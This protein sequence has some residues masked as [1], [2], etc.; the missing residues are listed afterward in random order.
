MSL[1][2]FNHRYYY[3]R[4]IE[5][6]SRKL[7]SK[8]SPQI[9]FDEWSTSG[10][11]ENRPR[12]SNLL[13]ILIRAELFTAADYVAGLIDTPL[14]QRPHDGPARCVDLSLPDGE[15]DTV[16]IAGIVEEFRYPFADTSNDPNKDNFGKQNDYN[17][18]IGLPQSNPEQSISDLMKFSV[19]SIDSQL[20]KLSILERKT[21]PSSNFPN[22]S[23]PGTSSNMTSNTNNESQS[24]NAHLEAMSSESSEIPVLSVLGTK[25]NNENSVPIP[26]LSELG[27][28][29]TIEISSFQ[30]PDITELGPRTTENSITNMPLISFTS[31]SSISTSNNQ[32]QY[33]PSFSALSINKDS[34]VAA[35]SRKASNT[36]SYNDTDDDDQSK[37]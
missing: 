5:E 27:T 32:T 12:M 9:L 24:Q 1:L 16:A 13:D 10:K 33:L 8:S 29:S 36:Q 15:S 22:L 21:S 6:E 37:S 3:F 23:V 18:V 34:S 4:K 31:R 26:F 20:P 19:N 30:L 25:S 11:R 28:R 14:P 2:I 7:G 35:S 17:K